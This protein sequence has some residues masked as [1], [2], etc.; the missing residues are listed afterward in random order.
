MNIGSGKGYPLSQLSSDSLHAFELDGVKATCLESLV[1]GLKFEKASQQVTVCREAPKA[2][3]ERGK[4]ANC[5]KNSQKLWW[6]GEAFDR[7]SESHR[8]LLHRAVA[9]MANQCPAFRQAL[10]DSGAIVLQSV[11]QSKEFDV[12]VTEAE[13]CATLTAVRAQ[14]MRVPMIA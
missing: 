2:A 7:R 10:I 14:L 9:Q 4:K 11:A 6:K 13:Y 1:Q 8:G 12:P 5:W 3:R